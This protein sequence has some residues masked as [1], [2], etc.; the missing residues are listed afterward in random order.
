MT[1]KARI[2]E[3]RQVL[4]SSLTNQQSTLHCAIKDLIEHFKTEII[5]SK[6][7]PKEKKEDWTRKKLVKPVCWML[8]WPAG[9]TMAPP[10]LNWNVNS[11]CRKIFALLIAGLTSQLHTVNV[12][13]L[14]HYLFSAKLSLGCRYPHTE[15]AAS[16][17]TCVFQSEACVELSTHT[18]THDHTSQQ[19]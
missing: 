12:K 10:S 1:F 8:P 19:Y 15:P 6:N 11:S 9:T 16:L 3:W 4:G 17:P 14:F 18:R 2:P 13:L 5:P 7:K